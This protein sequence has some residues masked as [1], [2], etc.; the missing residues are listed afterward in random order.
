MLLLFSSLCT[1]CITPRLAEI[2]SLLS[3]IYFCSL[4]NILIYVASLAIAS[5]MPYQFNILLIS[6]AKL[7]IINS[8]FFFL[9]TL[10]SFF[11]CFRY[12]FKICTRL[13][14]WLA[15]ENDIVGK[16]KKTYFAVSLLSDPL[17]TPNL[18][19]KLLDILYLRF[20]SLYI[21]L[22]ILI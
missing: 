15:Q 14:H 9:L 12:C 3:L 11:N 10:N 21:S 18:T 6:N 4:H 17:Y 16:K 19:R 20:C 22:T 7:K 13:L 2:Y 5:L 1:M 8:V